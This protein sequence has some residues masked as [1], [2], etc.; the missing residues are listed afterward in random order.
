MNPQ[1]Q[2]CHTLQGRARGQLGQGNIRVHSQAEQ[3]YGCRPCGQTC[4]APKG[5]PFYRVPT[6]VEV[7]TIVLTLLSHGCPLPAMVAAFGLDERT[8]A[9]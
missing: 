9:A 8:V 2:R 5:T 7:V 4:V 6:A 1:A 3:R